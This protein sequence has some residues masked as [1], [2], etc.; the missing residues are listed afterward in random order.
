[1]LSEIEALD[2]QLHEAALPLSE[3]A[4]GAVRGSIEHSPVGGGLIRR[5]FRLYGDCGTARAI[6]DIGRLRGSAAG[7]EAE[8]LESLAALLERKSAAL[9]RAR[10]HAR[11]KAVLEAWLYIHVPVTFAVFAAM[12]AHI[13]AVFFYS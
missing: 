1:M 11:T 12:A 8:A 13:I 6:R 9:S 4:A 3:A 2:R 10:R 7:P 5:L